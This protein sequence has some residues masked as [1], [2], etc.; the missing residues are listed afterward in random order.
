[1][2][3]LSEFHYDFARRN[4]RS[5][6]SSISLISGLLQLCS[7]LIFLP[8]HSTLPIRAFLMCLKNA[9]AERFRSSRK[10]IT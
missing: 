5:H 6:M 1:M 3:D 7:Y 4:A 8:C 2:A 9:R 10:A